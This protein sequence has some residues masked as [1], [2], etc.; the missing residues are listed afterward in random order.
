ME[1][2]L[3]SKVCR[4]DSQRHCAIAASVFFFVAATVV[5]ASGSESRKSAK[6]AHWVGTWASSPQLADSNSAPAPG[7]VDCTLRQ[8][9][10]LS[11]GGSQIRVRFSNAFGTTALMITSARVAKAAPSGSIQLESDRDLL[12][13]GR[14]STTIPAGALMYSDA[15]NFDARA[16]SDLAV[17][18][19]L[20]VAPEGV[21]THS[22]ARAT[23]YLA[24]GDEVSAAELSSPRTTDHWYFLN[25][26]DV[27]SNKSAAVVVLGDSITDGKNSSTNE[28]RR[29][30]DELARRLHA[31]KSTSNVGVL[32]EG[33]GGNRLLQDGLG[34]NG[35]ARLDRDVLAQTS[36]RW[37]IVLE[38][39]NDIG[40]CTEK[41]EPAANAQNIICAYQQIILR[42]HSQGIR[43]Y[44]ATITPFGRS[45]YDSAE[46]ER[47]RQTVNDWI[48]TSGQFD[49]VIDFDAA[50]RD[51]NN[52]L[53]LSA[54]ADSGDH[55]HPSDA[56]YKTMA[57]SVNL[58]LFTK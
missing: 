4:R 41:C 43:V 11:V 56:G 29:W 51:P 45:F 20:A 44:G 39:V 24:Q 18:I 13:Q 55:L 26:V 17:T 37:L 16:L 10:H 48:R 42:A 34:P 32:N 6:G 1:A 27:L 9:V 23:S 31:N 3:S 25:G 40:T 46:A 8:I 22:G 38:G 53:N 21:T 50:I 52:P 36:P 30:P 7:F 15:L 2:T 58:K 47:A 54:G 49:A 14:P 35:L 33:I 19:H 12:F 57:D 5:Q 28:N